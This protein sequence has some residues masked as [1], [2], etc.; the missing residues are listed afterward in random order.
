MP[1]YSKEEL[2]EYLEDN[3]VFNILYENYKANNFDRN[4]L[5][6]FDRIDDNLGYSFDN[7]RITTLRENIDKE[8][9]KGREG[10]SVRKNYTPVEQYDLDDNFIES[11]VSQNEASRRTGISL[12]SINKCVNGKAKSVCGYVFKFE[13]S[14]RIKKC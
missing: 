5:P 9:R 8:Y 3:D 13:S 2:V 7:I 11:F 6:G 1:E 14:K 10:T 4:L 12:M